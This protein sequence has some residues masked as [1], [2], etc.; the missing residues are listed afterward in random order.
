MLLIVVIELLLL[1]TLDCK[2]V[3][4]VSNVQS[5]VPNNWAYDTTP[6]VAPPAAA[7]KQAATEQVKL[8]AAGILIALI[9]DCKLQI[10]VTKA[11]IKAVELVGVEPKLRHD[12]FK[13]A[14]SIQQSVKI[15]HNC[16]PSFATTSLTVSPLQ[17][18]KQGM[19][20][21]CQ[22]TQLDDTSEHPVLL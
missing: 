3:T 6:N 12:K 1:T 10:L 2:V 9:C 13:V 18:L 4:V 14:I 19:L 20:G 15:S 5:L 11:C 7:C 22:I 16:S 8:A 21:P 17:R